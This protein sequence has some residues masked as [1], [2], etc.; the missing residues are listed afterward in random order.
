[1]TRLLITFLGLL[2]VATL[3]G[4]VAYQNA[5]SILNGSASIGNAFAFVL[6][7]I[8]FG[9]ALLVLGRIIYLTAPKKARGEV[10]L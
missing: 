6:G 2:T 5:A 10:Q 1:M 4:G 7:V 8:V 9:F 3:S